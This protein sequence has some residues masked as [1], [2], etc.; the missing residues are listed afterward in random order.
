GVSGCHNNP[1]V[2]V[3]MVVA[4]RMSLAEG[5]GYVVAQIVGGII[6]AGILLLILQGSISGYDLA[7]GGLGHN[8]WGRNY[9]GGYG[10]TAAFAA[11][12]IAT[13]IFVLV[14][15]VVTRGAET[16]AVAGLVIG[17]T[18]FALHLPFINVTGLSVNPARSIGPAVF[19][20]GQALA[21]L[22]LFIVAPVIGGVIAGLL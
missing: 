18:L 16:G 2:S 22:W 13:L 5:A 17:L 8:G 11:E 4:G 15:L 20:G 14:I 12:V 19:V 21:Q 7:G 10:T 3:A 6:R 9:L 1:A